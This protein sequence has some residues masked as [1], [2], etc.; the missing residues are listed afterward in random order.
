MKV[1]SQVIVSFQRFFDHDVL[2]TSLEQFHDSAR[3][4][5][6]SFVDDSRLF[7][8]SCQL[9]SECFCSSRLSSKL[10]STFSSFLDIHRA[11]ALTAQPNYGSARVPVF[12]TLN[13]TT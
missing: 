5:V 6:T 2:G 8:R 3:L 7:G 10:S 4:P 11:V 12:S 1:L 13:I 9:Q